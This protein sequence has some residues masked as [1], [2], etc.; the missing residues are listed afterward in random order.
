M[1]I[2]HVD[3]YEFLKGGHT[4]VVHGSPESSLASMEDMVRRST[5]VLDALAVFGCPRLVIFSDSDVG[6]KGLRIDAMRSDVFR[7]FQW[8]ERWV[9]NFVRACCGVRAAGTQVRLHR[10]STLTPDKRGCDAMRCDVM[11][12]CVQLRYRALPLRS[13][14]R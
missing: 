11:H 12:S 5:L 1:E 4:K 8:C 2:I 14:L 7:A 6:Q 9:E 3:F 13:C 10:S